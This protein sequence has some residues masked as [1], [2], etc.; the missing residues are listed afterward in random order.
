MIWKHLDKYRDF[1]LL[2]LRAAVG[3]YMA[4][5]HGLGKIMGGTGQWAQL[6]G[7]IEGILGFGFLPTF[8]GF[9]AAIAEFIG[10][11]LLTIGF[12]SR[13]AALLLVVNMSVASMAHITGVIDGSPE[14]ALI[15][16]AV[17]LSLVFTGPGAYSLDDQL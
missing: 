12:L 9:M 3:L 14:S 1:G 16:G 13:P 6:G 8:W 17:F 5:G 15:Y 4:F 7:V 2:F 10:A 11:L